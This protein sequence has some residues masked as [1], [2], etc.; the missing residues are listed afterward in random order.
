MSSANSTIKQ[1]H[2]NIFDDYTLNSTLFSYDEIHITVEN[3]ITKQKY[4]FIKTAKEI[5]ELTQRSK[6]EMEAE[7]LYNLYQM[8]VNKKENIQLTV[9]FDT[10][11]NL[12]LVINW[13][14]QHDDM[15]I[16][17]SFELTCQTVFQTDTERM[18]KM[19][20]DFIKY[21]ETLEKTVEELKN[22]DVNKKFSDV[23]D[24]VNSEYTNLWDRQRKRMD[25]KFEEL[26]TELNDAFN[27]VDQ[28]QSNLINV[29]VFSD[30]YTPTN[31]ALFTM[32]VNKKSKMSKLL[33]T[34]YFGYHGNVTTQKWT[35]GKES[36]TSITLPVYSTNGPVTCTVMINNHYETGPQTLSVIFPGMSYSGINKYCTVKVEEI[37]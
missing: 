30:F 8:A 17:R 15:K 3:N 29:T 22:L 9:K 10:I 13:T 24:Y 27:I 4:S 1:T 26:K 2:Q 5:L 36:S 35:Y 25:T 16:T 32:T 31:D 11:N 34:G 19:F 33:I 14:I 20:K 23:Y 37:I 7:Q 21:K 18:E 12:V 28:G 6:F